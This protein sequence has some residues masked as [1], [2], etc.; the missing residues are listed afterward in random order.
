VDQRRRLQRLARLLL[1]QL[2][3][4]ELAQLVVDQRQ[5]LRGGVRGALV[6]GGQNAR[7][8][9]HTGRI[10]TG[11]VDRKD[12][13]GHDA[14]RPARAKD[15]GFSI[16]YGGRGICVESLD[17]AEVSVFG[18]S[19][20]GAL[21]SIEFTIAPQVRVSNLSAG[22]NRH[23]RPVDPLAPRPWTALCRR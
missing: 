20:R 8:I 15:R 14:S 16:S 1:G 18:E 3:G 13:N 12:G 7:D 4:R 6:D 21:V 9:V 17:G 22:R 19:I 10:T 5:E 2:L 23:R 11:V